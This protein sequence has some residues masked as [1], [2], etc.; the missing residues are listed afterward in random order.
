M[1]PLATPIPVIAFAKPFTNSV[2]MSYFD[3]TDWIAAGNI[4]LGD[5]WY[6]AAMTVKDT[7]VDLSIGT[8]GPYTDVARQYTGGFDRVTVAYE[9]RSPV[10][11]YWFG[12][13]DL[14]VTGVPEP[15]SLAL[16]ALGDLFLRRRR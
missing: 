12:I 4:D 8:Y 3:G 16:F 10:G 6:N 2:A 15:A 11:A 5:T 7:T 9:G 14:T 1:S 13:D